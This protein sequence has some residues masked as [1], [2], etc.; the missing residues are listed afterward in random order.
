MIEAV[1]QQFWPGTFRRWHVCSNQRPRLHQSI[2]IADERLFRRRYVDST[3]FIQQYI[4]PGGCLP[5]RDEFRRQAHAAGFD[6][7]DEF[8]FGQDYAHTLKLWRDWHKVT[9]ASTRV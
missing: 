6:I 5:A 8:S 9:G 7:V 2:V 4:F 1:G 3:D